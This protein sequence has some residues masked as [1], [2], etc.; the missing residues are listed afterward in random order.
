MASYCGKSWPFK[1]R[2]IFALLLFMASC[3]ST[4]MES[5]ELMGDDETTPNV[6]CPASSE[7]AACPCYKFEDANI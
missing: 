1:S 7:N 4:I 3:R 6:E 5:L 2:W